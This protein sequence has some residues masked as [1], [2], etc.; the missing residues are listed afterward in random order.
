MPAGHSPAPSGH[1]ESLEA[2]SAHILRET[3]AVTRNPVLLFSGG[4][5]SAL[6]LELAA[7]AFAPGPV[8]FPALHIDTG[9]NFEEVLDFRDRTVRRFGIR[10]LVGHVAQD[11]AAAAA[12]NPKTTWCVTVT[13]QH[14]HAVGHGCARPEPKGHRKRAGPGPRGGGGFSFTP[15]SRDGPPGGP[16]QPHPADPAR[17]DAEVEHAHRRGRLVRT[18][19]GAGQQLGPEVDHAEFD[20]DAGRDHGGQ[21]PAHQRQPDPPRGT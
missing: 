16:G 7:R 12:L 8:P 11:L 1:L 10:L 9:H 4:K 2:E 3:A 15:V 14:G 6:L 13:D 5:D 20:R 21:Q 17:Q 18:Q 19:P